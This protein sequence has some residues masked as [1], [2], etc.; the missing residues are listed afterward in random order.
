MR[1][2]L[3]AFLILLALQVPLLA[4]ETAPPKPVAAASGASGY[5]ALKAKHGAEVAKEFE[6]LYSA[7][8]EGRVRRET[9]RVEESMDSL[10]Y[11]IVAFAVVAGLLAIAAALKSQS[12]SR[13][14]ARLRAIV[15]ELEAARK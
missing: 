6:A 2:A 11:G 8:V 3:L 15:D 1:T 9:A 13:E 5:E 10:F 14:L 7:E 4:N 12:H